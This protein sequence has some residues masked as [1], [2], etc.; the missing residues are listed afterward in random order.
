MRTTHRG[1]VF[2]GIVVLSLGIMLF[3]TS[4]SG[5][6]ECRSALATPNHPLDSNMAD[7]CRAAVS[8]HYGSMATAALGAL[9]LGLGLAG[10]K[11]RPTVATRSRTD[12][13][14]APK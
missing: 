2:T 8:W 10:T 3:L 7:L 12:G 11:V 6:A 4:A 1:I 9:L 14:E 13:P 5:Y